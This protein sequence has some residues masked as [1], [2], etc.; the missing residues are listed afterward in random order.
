[1]HIGQGNSYQ[2]TIDGTSLSCVQENKDL[3]VIVSYDLNT[4]T[5]TFPYQIYYSSSSQNPFCLGAKHH[6]ADCHN[7][8]RQCRQ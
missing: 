2:Y 4:I 8:A 5:H 1:M 7:T 3:R 6:I